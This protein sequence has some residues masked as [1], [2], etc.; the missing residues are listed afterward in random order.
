MI[1]RPDP[2]LVPVSMADE[3][4]EPLL[5]WATDRLAA[6]GFGDQPVL[7]L[8]RRRSWSLV[9]RLQTARGPVWAKANARPFAAE[10]GLTDLLAVHA[11]DHVLAPI[12]LD[13]ERG[14]LLLPDGGPVL[15]DLGTTEHSHWRTLLLGYAEL[16]QAMAGR[17]GALRELGLP[18]MSP[19]TL[20]AWWESVVDRSAEDERVWQ[21]L[22]TGRFQ[23]G[24]FQSG[25]QCDLTADPMH[26]LRVIGP[27]VEF[28]AAELAAGGIPV[29][30][31]HTDLHTGNVF[32]GP[33][34][35]AEFLR[36][37]DWGDAVIAHPFVGLGD[38][39]HTAAADDPASGQSID[40]A[41]GQSIDT[42]RSAYLARWTIAGLH[43]RPTPVPD[44]R[45]LEAL[46][47][48]ALPGGALTSAALPSHALSSDAL[49]N[50]AIPGGAV[51]G[52]A[53][54]SDALRRDAAVAEA[55]SPLM[56]AASWLRIPGGLP[57]HFVEWFADLVAQLATNIRELDHRSGRAHP[58]H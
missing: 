8:E 23:S 53:L 44:A 33:P 21:L 34:D 25:F 26:T 40:T 11:P 18:D 10:A 4:I 14:L 31:E 16:Q 22:S 55:F 52:D 28:W 5:R 58:D 3:S 27:S 32:A 37:I 20:L 46:P 51:P 50:D 54:P 6:A 24:R 29:T 12:A 48:R 9:L 57:T 19:P 35:R 2:R 17:L 13:V 36:I 7:D 56:V 43:R 41:S 1:S 39:L 47:G 30:L 49:S 45:P 42:L 15:S 38:I